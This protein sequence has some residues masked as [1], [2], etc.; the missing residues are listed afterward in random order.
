MLI[1][2]AFERR[3]GW[4]VSVAADPG[5]PA[6]KLDAADAAKAWAAHTGPGD[7][8]P[9]TAEVLERR[10]TRS[11]DALF[12]AGLKR[13]LTPELQSLAERR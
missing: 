7:V 4:P 3:R 11:I 10:R 5:A 12:G 2:R 13:P 6:H 9:L 1:A 8:R